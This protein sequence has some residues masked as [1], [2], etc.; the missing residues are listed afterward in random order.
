MKRKKMKDENMIQKKELKNIKAHKQ[1]F[2]IE[3]HIKV[4]HTEKLK[5]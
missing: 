1:K 5:R 3:T 2:L 4:K